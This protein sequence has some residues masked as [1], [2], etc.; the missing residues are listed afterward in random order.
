[1]LTCQGK[2]QEYNTI[3][4]G[5]WRWDERKEKWVR[6]RGIERGRESYGGRDGRR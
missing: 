1:M 5:E 4:G 2:T 6:E 3:V